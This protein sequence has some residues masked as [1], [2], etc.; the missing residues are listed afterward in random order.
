MYLN[1][2]HNYLTEYAKDIT[3]K[4]ILNISLGKSHSLTNIK[5]LYLD[6]YIMREIELYKIIV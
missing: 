1:N 6:R 3:L 5:I 2:P 4:R